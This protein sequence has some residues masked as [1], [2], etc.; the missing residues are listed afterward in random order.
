MVKF[1]NKNIIFYVWML[2][3]LTYVIGILVT[4][5]FVF[6][7][8]L[9][10]LFKN[11][12]F[13][14]YKN[15]MF[16]Y[17]LTI[18]IYIGIN[19]FINIPHNDLLISSI[20]HFRFSLLIITIFFFIDHL[21]SQE[22]VI[23]SIFL[24]IIFGVL[25]FIFFD[26]LVQFILGKN[27]FGYEIINY[28]R[29]S[30]I[31]GSE[32][33]LGSFL[34]KFLPFMVW[35]IFFFKFDTENKKFFLIFF[36]SIYFIIIY[37]SGE[38]TSFA[39]MLLTII[40]SA[41]FINKIK[42]IYLISFGIL[43]L[44]VILTNTLKIGKA[45][46]YDRLI[47]KTF[48]QI[49]SQ[50]FIKNKDNT[51]TS[52]KE[53]SDNQVKDNLVLFSKDHNGH[54]ILAYKLF[55]ESPFFGV[56]PKGFRY[57]CRIIDYDS[58][59][60]MCSTHPHNIPVQILSELGILGFVLYVYG[61]FFIIRNLINYSNKKDIFEKD[62][63]CFIAATISLIINFFPFL[64]SGNFFNNWM[65]INNFFYIGIYFYSYNKILNKI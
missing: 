51:N 35:L 65:S 23:N 7:L 56:G 12:K 19:G 48:N 57:H 26:A 47:N 6:I 60:G 49:T 52:K 58:E 38:R 11:R 16:L 24:K 32:F 28:H 17:F 39:L 3:P 54:Y 63:Y 1:F 29:I 40:I 36:F 13:Q 14:I 8:T 10:F 50:V 20:F 45:D 42:E 4:E 62:K 41:L 37:L 31:F 55:T 44:F 53:N 9:Y 30:G 5:A 25:G 64:P 21:E 27:I 18:S 61:L 43:I 59:V 15:K 46:P 2:L 22:I 33:I 34:T